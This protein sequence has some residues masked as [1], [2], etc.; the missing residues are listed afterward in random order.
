MLKATNPV[1]TSSLEPEAGLYRVC[2]SAA[3]LQAARQSRLSAIAYRDAAPAAAET[4]KG[5]C[6]IWLC[7]ARNARLI[8]R[9]AGARLP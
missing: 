5:N 3:F 6:R 8:E 9:M 1:I 2:E 7:P 4:Y